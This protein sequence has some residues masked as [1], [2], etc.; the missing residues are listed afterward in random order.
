LELTIVPGLLQTAAY[1]TA[2]EGLDVDPPG[3]DEVARRVAER[4]AR[5]RVLDRDDP[6]QLLAVLDRGIL[7]DE[8]GGP[9]VMAEQVAHLAEMN[10]RSNVTVRLLSAAGRIAA[11]N[12]PFKL[13]TG[14]DPDP[15][16]VVTEDLSGGLSYRGGPTVVG[17][18]RGLWQ[19]VW[20]R[21]SH[22]LA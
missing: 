8:V 7:G 18:Y 9:A 11:S 3:P 19:F 20:E 21:G 13:L 12:G 16:L 14:D 1:A 10:E 17:V 5:Q 22:A 2:V 15:F 6:L 4:L